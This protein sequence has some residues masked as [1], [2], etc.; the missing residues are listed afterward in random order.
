MP[1]LGESVTEGVVTRW[2]KQPG[3]QVRAAEPLLE[4][5]GRR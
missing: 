1:T 3:E 4:G 2:L 5:G